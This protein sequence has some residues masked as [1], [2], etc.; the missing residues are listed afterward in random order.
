MEGKDEWELCWQDHANEWSQDPCF[1]GTESLYSDEEKAIVGQI[2]V[3]IAQYECF[4][5]GLMEA[6]SGDDMDVL[7]QCV[8]EPTGELSATGEKIEDAFESC[9]AG[10]QTDE[11]PRSLAKKLVSREMD[12]D[13][14]C[15][16]YNDTMAF[17]SS[18]YGDDSCVLGHMGWFLTNGTIGFN[19][20]AFTDDINGLPQ[21]TA[22]VTIIQVTLQ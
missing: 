16:N 11:T 9:F 5:H 15:Y 10:N 2:G 12:D 17:I 8:T 3:M 22:E 21:A 1:N 6:C 19:L 4:R 18:Y 13:E 7:E 14:V 20:T